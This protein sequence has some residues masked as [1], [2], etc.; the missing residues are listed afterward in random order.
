MIIETYDSVSGGI[1]Q[2]ETENGL[3]AV[4]L[5]DIVQGRHGQPMVF[6][7]MRGS[8][9]EIKTL[10][11]RLIDQGISDS[12]Y[13]IFT[14]PSFIPNV[15]VGNPEYTFTQLTSSSF[16]IPLTDSVSDYAWI[17]IRTDYDHSGPSKT[18][19]SLEYIFPEEV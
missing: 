6:R 18:V 19:L 7:C 13:S 3:F 5:A 8:E 15:S 2:Q 16:S 10:Y 4:D 12:I 1:I 17:D 9:T 11:I 14:S